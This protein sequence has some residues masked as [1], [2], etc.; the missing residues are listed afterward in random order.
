MPDPQSPVLAWRNLFLLGRTVQR[1]L[2][3]RLTAEVGCTLQEHDLLTQLSIAPE[4]RCRMLEIAE[5]L[6]V[7]RGGLTR[8]V[9]RMVA[10]SW[11]ERERPESNRREVYA[12]LTAT[13]AEVLGR[14][15]VV[16]LATVDEVVRSSLDPAEVAELTR[17]T[18]KLLASTPGCP[19]L[20]ADACAPAPPEA[21]RGETRAAG[22]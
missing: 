10:R 13:G 12:V 22:G 20:P 18:G 21:G 15:R 5:L 7:T 19:V 2:D 16:Y 8:I 1:V 6:G 3:R 4:R 9:D 17:V 11:V 14:A